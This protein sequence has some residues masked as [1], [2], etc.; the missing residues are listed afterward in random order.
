MPQSLSIV[1]L[2]LVFSTKDRRPFLRDPSLRVKSHLWLGAA[3]REL[4]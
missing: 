1:Y 2:H 3:S 4:G